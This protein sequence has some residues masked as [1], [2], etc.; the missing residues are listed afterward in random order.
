[1]AGWGWAGRRGMSCGVSCGMRHIIAAP[2]LVPGGKTGCFSALGAVTGSL[3]SLRM[4]LGRSTAR[5]A[6]TGL[7]CVAGACLLASGLTWGRPEPATGRGAKPGL[8]RVAKLG[9]NHPSQRFSQPRSQPDSPLPAALA[10]ALQQAQVPPEALA[11]L[12]LP[13]GRSGAIW[14][15]QPDLAMQPAST[16]KLVT[17][18]VALDRLGPNHRGFTEL[19]TQAPQQNDVLAGD[20]VL[21][22]GADPELGLMQLWALL[23]ELRWM[24]IREIAGDIVLDRTL[25]RPARA[26]ASVVTGPFDER[27]E[28]AYNA[29]PDALQLNNNLLGLELASEGAGRQA[30]VVARLLPPLPGLEIDASE[31]RLT[32]R[33][34]RDWGDDWQSP[35]LQAEP[36]PGRLR[37][38]LR[39]GFPKSCVKRTALALINRDALAERHLRW[40][41]EGL[42]GQWRGQLR[43]AA[44]PLIAPVPAA[45]VATAL[46]PPGAAKGG[47][48]VAPGVAW[49][50][51]AGFTPPGVRVLARRLARPW[52]EVLRMMNKQ[53][54]NPSTR[55]LFLS[56]G[57]AGMADEPTAPTADLA[58]RVVRDWLVA[59]RINPTGLVLDNGSGLSRSERIT[60]RQLAL[61]LKAAQAGR[62]GPELMMSLP[63]AGVDGT[64]RNRLKTGPAAGRARLKSGTLKNVVSLAGYVPDDQGRLWAVAAMINHEQAIAARPALDALIDWV[65]G[66]GMGQR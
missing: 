60:P 15:R 37:I 27:P 13:V 9:T 12:V 43:E 40:V 2:G 44:M 65:A 54:D 36:E 48:W 59:Q 25:F 19:L 31:L 22:G 58:A 45:A 4:D 29:T 6:R 34:C 41:W 46:V 63:L 21:R 28:F 53:S 23:S 66:G 39:G 47:A 32:D 7:W 26:D 18:I 38:T 16:M 35:P 14:Q 1:M 24:G 64:L 61:M 56:L 55:L 62:W 49:G 8:P 30:G 10:D 17:S 52:G 42:G 57:L 51:T 50:G 33:A 11:A 3:K 20:L 5:L